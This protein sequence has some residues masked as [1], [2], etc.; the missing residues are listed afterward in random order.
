MLFHCFRMFNADIKPLVCNLTGFPQME[1]SYHLIPYKKDPTV[2][3]K[4]SL[5]HVNI[6]NRR[7]H[8]AFYLMKP[9]ALSTVSAEKILQREES[10]A[11]KISKPVKDRVSLIQQITTPKP[12]RVSVYV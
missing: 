9:Y 7:Q 12:A 10:P 1:Q 5:E 8:C 3:L 11:V 4:V 6:H 2:K